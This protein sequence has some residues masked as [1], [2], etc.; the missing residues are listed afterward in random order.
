MPKGKSRRN[1]GK[2]KWRRRNHFNQIAED[3]IGDI[4]E[5]IRKEGFDNLP[6]VEAP[7]DVSKMFNI[8]TRPEHEKQGKLDPKRFT[9]TKHRPMAKIDQMKVDKMIRYGIPQDPK[10]TNEI[11]D[12]WGNETK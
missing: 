5:Q 7:K 12:L 10:T 6:I 4:Q 9:K 11:F 8:D 2:K 1:I 3:M